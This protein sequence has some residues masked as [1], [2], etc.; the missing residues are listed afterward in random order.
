MYSLKGTLRKYNLSLLRSILKR[1]R[2]A[3]N[4]PPN[5]LSSLAYSVAL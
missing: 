5:A 4:S 2:N 1:R 3:Q